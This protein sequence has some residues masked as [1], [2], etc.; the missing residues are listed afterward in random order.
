MWK[1]G[2]KENKQPERE[3][4]EGE[5]RQKRAALMGVWAFLLVS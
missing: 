3:Q 4:Q 5:E 2:E 1:E